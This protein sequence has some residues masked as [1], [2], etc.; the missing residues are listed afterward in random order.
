MR[1]LCGVGMALRSVGMLAVESTHGSWLMIIDIFMILVEITTQ[2]NLPGIEVSWP[3]EVFL[4]NMCVAKDLSA[5][6]F[7]I[8]MST[9][10]S[11]LQLAQVPVPSLQQV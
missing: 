6:F 2:R 9:I 5:E 1:P 8:L 11:A 7:G 4:G 3:D 10:N